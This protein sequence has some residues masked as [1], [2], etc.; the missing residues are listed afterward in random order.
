MLNKT[1]YLAWKLG[2]AFEKLP[3]APS[4]KSAVKMFQLDEKCGIQF[5]ETQ[6]LLL[7]TIKMSK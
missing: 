1:E 6:C 7:L 3:A 5:V 2:H 4:G